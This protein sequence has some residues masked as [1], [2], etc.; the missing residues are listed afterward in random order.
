MGGGGRSKQLELTETY[1]KIFS[2]LSKS[3]YSPDS[4]LFAILLVLMFHSPGPDSGEHTQVKR[5][6]KIKVAIF[7]VFTHSRDIGVNSG[8]S[9]SYLKLKFHLQASKLGVW[10][11][12]G[13]L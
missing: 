2:Y 3:Q 8:S 4:E 6:P 10:L 13:H 5:F 11:I 7:D 9:G 12:K 1:H